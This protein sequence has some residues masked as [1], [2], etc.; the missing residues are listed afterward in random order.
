MSKF[1]ITNIVIAI[2]AL[3]SVLLQ[4]MGF[5]F[6][7]VILIAG[8]VV[9]MTLLVCGVVNVNWQFFMPITNEI[10]NS[11][12]QIF[13][14]FDDGPQKQSEVVLDLLKLHD[15]KANFFCIGKH[16]EENPKL[17][18]R[19]FDEGHFVGSHS[20]LHE[21]KFPLKSLKNIVDELKKT[22]QIIEG[23]SGR[24]SIFFRLPFGVS[25]PTVARAVA[26]LNMKCIGWNIRSF[27]TS[28]RRGM[29]A[30]QKIKRKIKPGDI[31]LLHDHSS[32]VIPILEEL[33]PFLKEKNYK[34]HRIDIALSENE[35]S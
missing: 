34:A 4:V 14:S 24:K 8:L 13:L 27:D 1:T 28:E 10:P 2:V 9:Y 31:I 35:R 20:Y 5:A 16:L 26:I 25:N 22:N 7:W 15:I 23:Y 11:E 33:I 30:L 19:L 21:V 17:T 6:Y 3:L 29:K 18:Q 12:K 32:H